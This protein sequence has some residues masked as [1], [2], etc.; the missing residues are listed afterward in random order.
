MIRRVRI[1]DRLRHVRCLPAPCMLA[2]PMLFVLSVLFGKRISF[3]EEIR[4]SPLDW[5]LHRLSSYA[6]F[7]KNDRKI[8]NLVKQAKVHVLIR[9]SLCYN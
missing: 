6:F 7:N 8:E 5:F 3:K 4:L 2:V 1:N 9:G